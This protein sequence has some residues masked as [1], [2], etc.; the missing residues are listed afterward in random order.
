MALRGEGE[1]VK[2]LR[3]KSGDLTRVEEGGDEK[4]RPSP[5]PPPPLEIWALSED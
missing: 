5:P 2:S 4:V 1:G 3:C